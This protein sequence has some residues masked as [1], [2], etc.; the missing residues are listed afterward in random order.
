MRLVMDDLAIELARGGY[1]RFERVGEEPDSER[2]PVDPA[3]MP[4]EALAD[5]LVLARLRA[6]GQS[7]LARLGDG[8]PLATAVFRCGCEGVDEPGEQ[9]A[10]IGC[11]VEEVYEARRRLR[12]HGAI[13]KAE[14]EETDRARAASVS[15]ARGDRRTTRKEALP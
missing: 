1:A 9:A 3:P 7:L 11:S 2:R 15:R 8:D 5:Q 10:H 4:D 12:Y 14:A 13:V 6:L